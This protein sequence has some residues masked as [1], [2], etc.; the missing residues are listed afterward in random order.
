MTTLSSQP[1]DLIP[2]YPEYD[3]HNFITG[4]QLSCNEYNESILPPESFIVTATGLHKTDQPR[5]KVLG[6]SKFQDIY[7]AY[8]D[9]CCPQPEE[10]TAPEQYNCR[11]CNSIDSIKNIQGTLV[12]TNCGL[13]HGNEISQELECQTLSKEN[14]NTA[15]S[16]QVNNTLLPQSNFCT[17]IVGNKTSHRLKQINNV[18]DSIDYKERTL[19]KI[20]K[21]ISDDCRQNGIPNNVI[22]YSQVLYKQVHE[23]QRK[24][25][26]GTRGS[27]SDKLNGL[28]AGCIFYACKAYSINRSHQEIADICNIVKKD[29]SY[30]CKI[31]FRLMH[32]KIDLTLNHTTYQ[33]FIERFSSYLQLTPD[34]TKIIKQT[35]QLISEQNLM[36]QNKPSTVVAVTIYFC[37]QIYGFDLSKKD[38]A[39]HCNTTP[40]TLEKNHKILTESAHLILVG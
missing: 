36:D 27:R 37:S 11:T 31:F 4:S 34:E 35:C 16:G 28:I 40:A 29:V 10:P 1:E 21:K 20:F 33:N 7:Q 9:L 13:E 14:G 5:A 23:E 12:C 15:R 22:S 3:N 26:K 39:E 2:N 24:Q 19:M 32:D 17:K 6:N 25:R 8:N 18:W 30:G 38:I